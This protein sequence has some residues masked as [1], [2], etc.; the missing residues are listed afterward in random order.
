MWGNGGQETWPRWH[1][2]L[3]SWHEDKDFLISSPILLCFHAMGKPNNQAEEKVKMTFQVSVILCFYALVLDVEHC[4]SCYCSLTLSPLV[5]NSNHFFLLMDTFWK[6]ILNT[7]GTSYLCSMMSGTSVG[8][9]WRWGST[10][11]LGSET[12][13]R[14]FH[15]CIY[16][17]MLTIGWNLSWGC[18]LEFLELASW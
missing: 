13:Q 15:C 11:L 4:S 8:K 12:T 17:S 16:R 14:L 1:S 7:M 9:T 5:S 18:Q 2:S 3:L 6:G 10:W